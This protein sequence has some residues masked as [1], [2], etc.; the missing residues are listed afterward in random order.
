[1]KL[2]MMKKNHLTITISL[3]ILLAVMPFF[4]FMAVQAS[5]WSKPRP[6][7]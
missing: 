3:L 1:M 6:Q 2:I 5:D 7:T 4:P